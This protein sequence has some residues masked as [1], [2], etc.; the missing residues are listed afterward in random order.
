MSD[1]RKKKRKAKYMHLLRRFPATTP[2]SSYKQIS[3]AGRGPIRLRDS[4]Q[5]IRADQLATFEWRERQGFTTDY[6]EYSY[7]RVYVD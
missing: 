2:C 6:R 7:V 5:E 3:Y 4:L 1:L